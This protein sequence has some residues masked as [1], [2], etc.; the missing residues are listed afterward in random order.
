MSSCYDLRVAWVNFR[1]CQD[2]FNEELDAKITRSEC[3]F[4]AG[5]AIHEILF[6]P[7]WENPKYKEE[8]PEGMRWTM[9]H[10]KSAYRRVAVRAKGLVQVRLRERD[11]VPYWSFHEKDPRLWEFESGHDVFINQPMT[12][13]ELFVILGSVRDELGLHD[14]RPLLARDVVDRVLQY[15]TASSFNLGSF[16][17]TVYRALTNQLQIQGVQF[18][19]SDIVKLDKKLVLFEAGLDEFVAEDFEI[20]VPAYK[21]RSSWVVATPS[22]S[23]PPLVSARIDLVRTEEG[24]RMT[25]IQSSSYRPGFHFEGESGG[26]G[27]Y[28]DSL[29]PNPLSPGGKGTMVFRF[30]MSW[31][32]VKD[33]VAPGVKFRIMEG[34]KTV[35]HGEITAISETR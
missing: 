31:D 14:L 9:K 10:P 18:L 25:P 26:Y 35:G 17:T 11:W 6:Y 22:P 1:E 33:Q 28:L 27:I 8:P 23:Q 13:N 7:Y 4:V 24:G 21:Y 16:P 3:D 34:N 30:I 15:G 29:E 12:T 19:A 5:T 32:I 2:W 20:N